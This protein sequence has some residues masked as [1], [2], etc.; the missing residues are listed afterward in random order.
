MWS[1]NW[2]VNKI[3]AAL[4]GK[5]K[6]ALVTLFNTS[7]SPYDTT[8]TFQL[9]QPVS[10]PLNLSTL[11]LKL[12]TVFHNMMQSYNYNTGTD[13]ESSDKNSLSSSFLFQYSMVL[14]CLDVYTTVIEDTNT[15]VES[16][17]KFMT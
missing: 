8:G 10:A 4:M 5:G 9:L 13:L 3:V 2:Q 7:I 6:S 15:F 11:L 14:K 16:H 17:S 1:G 12:N